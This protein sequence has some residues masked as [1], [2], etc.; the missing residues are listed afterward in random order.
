MIENFSKDF[1]D[2]IYGTIHHHDY[3]AGRAAELIKMYGKVRF[4]EVGCACGCLVKALRDH[5]ADAYGIDKSQY[6]ISES[7]AGEYI[8]LADAQNLPFKDGEFDVVHSWAMFGYNNEAETEA[9]LR[10]CQRVG[11]IQY[12]T[13]DYQIADIP[14]MT[15]DK[16]TTGVT[17]PYG[18]VF[19]QPREWWDERIKN[20]A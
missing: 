1:Y 7:C 2:F 10:E 17:Y 20:D 4:L 12:H 9:I 6:A 8:Q 3:V 19:M 18:Y 5:G 15:K 16:L 13:I 14:Y 11:K